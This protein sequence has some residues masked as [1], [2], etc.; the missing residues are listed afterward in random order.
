MVQISFT[1]ETLGP[2]FDSTKNRT[3]PHIQYEDYSEYLVVWR[4]ERI[5]LYK[6]YASALS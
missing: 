6:N 3:T 1:A 2:N 5:E 4:K